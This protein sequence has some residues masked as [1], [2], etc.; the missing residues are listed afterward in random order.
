MGHILL[1][2]FQFAVLG[3]TQHYFILQMIEISSMTYVAVMTCILMVLFIMQDL[4][5]TTPS[6]FQTFLLHL[7][8]FSMT[9]IIGMTCIFLILL[10]KI[11]LH[12]CAFI[13][14]LGHHT[15]LRKCSFKC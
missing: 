10:Q 2:N 11:K 12:F 13:H 14:G 6:I 7:K 3:R 1:H 8:M 4:Q 9:C 5:T 15:I